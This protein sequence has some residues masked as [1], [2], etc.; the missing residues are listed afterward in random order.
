[1]CQN[2]QEKDGVG[3]ESWYLLAPYWCVEAGGAE[4]VSVFP[5]C[6]VWVS[7][8]CGRC[9]WERA[10]EGMKAMALDIRLHALDAMVLPFGG[11]WCIF[12]LASGQP[13]SGVSALAH[14]IHDFSWDFFYFWWPPKAFLIISFFLPSPSF[15]FISIFIYFSVF[16]SSSEFKRGTSDCHH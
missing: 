8:L 3:R 2:W 13:S 5:P 14:L 16:S 15:D 4:W 1:M 7:V 10:S 11:W 9:D 6:P 12:L